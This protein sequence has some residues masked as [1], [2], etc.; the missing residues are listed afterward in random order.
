MMKQTLSIFT[1]VIGLVLLGIGFLLLKAQPEMASLPYPYILIGVGCGAFG[2]GAGSIINRKVIS[3]HPEM[4][5][6]AEIEQKDE[7]NQT[8][9]YM[10]KAKAY[11]CMV[12]VFGA[13]MLT[14]ALM[15]KDLSVTLL[16]V[17]SY[18]F[19]IGYGVY[20]RIKYDKEM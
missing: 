19:V 11:D 13:L 6:K 12:F 14:F 7:R 2:S 3:K 18:L 8:I 5:K 4:A 17:F 16:L 9:G 15:N 1:T 20:Y 10:A